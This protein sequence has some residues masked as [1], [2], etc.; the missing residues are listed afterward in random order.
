MLRKIFSSLRRVPLFS[1][2]T[3]VCIGWVYVRA[4]SSRAAATAARV[5]G[6]HL[7]NIWEQLRRRESEIEPEGDRC[8]S[9]SQYGSLIRRIS[10]IFAHMAQVAR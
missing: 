7:S 8:F 6:R 10:G 9:S 5:Y 2:T 1:T 3:A 4:G